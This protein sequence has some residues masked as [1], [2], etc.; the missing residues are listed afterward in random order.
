MRI[1][2]AAVAALALAPAAQAS[3]LVTRD[4]SGVMLRVSGGSAVV[5]WT[6]RGARRHAVLSGAINAR[7]PSTSVPQVAFRVA[8][9]AGAVPGGSCGAYDGPALP[10]LVTACKAPDGSYWA[11]QRWQRLAANYGG[12]SAPAELHA[13]HWRGDLPKLEVWL[14][15][16]YG[17]RFEHLFGRLTYLGKPVHGFHSTGGGSPL[18]AYGRNL[19]LDT[20]DSAYG[21]GWRRE[22][23]FLTHKGTGVFCY[24]FYQHGSRPIGVGSTYR[25][26]VQGPGVTPVVSWVG[27]SPGPFDRALDAE[28]NALQLSLGDRL[29]RKA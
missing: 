11:L 6:S 4:A 5:S 8:Y 9:G 2:L 3:F 16:S 12:R 15:W 19:Y 23:S 27:P 13:S 25:L 22:N 18:D 26:L 20:L 1:L 7:P 29:C 17:G 28:M 21:P 24:G 14:D 10:L